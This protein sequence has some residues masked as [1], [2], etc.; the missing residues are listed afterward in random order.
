MGYE[1]N[2]G[3]PSNPRV[4]T[5]TRQLVCALV[6][7]SKESTV[8]LCTSGHVRSPQEDDRPR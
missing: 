7:A 3:T 2:G 1:L 5:N 6:M 8:L 4:L